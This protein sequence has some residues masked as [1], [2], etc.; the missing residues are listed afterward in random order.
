M[1]GPPIAFCGAGGGGRHCSAQRLQPL[2]T[3]CDAPAIG[4]IDSRD[5]LVSGLRAQNPGP[6]AVPARPRTRPRIG[7]ARA[8]PPR[9]AC[10]APLHSRV[11]APRRLT[12]AS[13]GCAECFGCLG[14]RVACDPPCKYH[15]P[16][17][18][19]RL[20]VLAGAP[21]GS[22]LASLKGKIES[23]LSARRVAGPS[24]VCDAHRPLDR[25]P[26]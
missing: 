26:I 9:V 17:S 23:H 10:S 13:D 4:V 24:D 22:P 12:H 11:R 1:T 3:G 2:D 21:A 5:S 15:A 19:A 16:C 18:P 25:L 6:W 7:R 14:T 20:R 8:R